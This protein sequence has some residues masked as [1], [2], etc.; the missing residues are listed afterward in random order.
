MP[1]TLN[2]FASGWMR[3]EKSTLALSGLADDMACFMMLTERALCIWSET[4][5]AHGQ[6]ITTT[7]PMK[8]LD[9][10][11]SAC[12]LWKRS[13]PGVHTDS[14]CHHHSADTTQYSRHS[15]RPYNAEYN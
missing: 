7:R 14:S 3:H 12:T 10:S 5:L 9:T 15:V 6:N 4:K 13:S 1:R 2:D 11:G 8:K